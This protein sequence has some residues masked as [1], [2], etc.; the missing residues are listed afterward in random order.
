MIAPRSPDRKNPTDEAFEIKLD[1]ASPAM[2]SAEMHPRVQDANAVAGRPPA[3]QTMIRSRCDAHV[4][5]SAS[6][7]SGGR[8][9]VRGGQSC[10][11]M[12]GH[13][14]CNYI[15]QLSLA[16]VVSGSK[17]GILEHHARKLLTKTADED[18]KS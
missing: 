11:K 3:T 15:V 6:V 8:S 2:E 1:Q 10:K 17:R 9:S 7:V 12:K 13:G 18:E 5:D 16:E 14:M 4:G